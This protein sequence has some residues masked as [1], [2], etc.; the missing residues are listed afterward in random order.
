MRIDGSYKFQNIPP[1]EV[2]RFMTDP[3]LISRCLPGCESL[4]KT[5]EDTYQMTLKLGVGPV[6][7]T[8]SGVIRLHDLNPV[9]EYKM[10]VSGKGVPGF[11]QGEGKVALVPMDAGTQL[12][13]SG[14]VTAGGAIAGVGQ[15]M[16]G[17]AA[18]LVIDQFFKCAG[19][20]LSEASSNG[21]RA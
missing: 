1:G 18:R 4:A 6:R 21:G 13:Y 19:L 5:G 9:S 14:V 11:V 15:R 17:G 16:I 10:S 20:R 12:E 3:V 8:F 7:G 2:W